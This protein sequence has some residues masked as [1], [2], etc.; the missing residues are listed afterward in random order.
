[1]FTDIERNEII[2]LIKHEVTP[3]IG[4]TEP[5]A[6][7]LAVAKA[8]EVLGVLPDK[9]EVFLSTNMLKN[10]MGVG[11]PGTGMVGL[12]I[13]IALGALIG[14]SEYKLQVLKDVTPATLELGKKMINEK[15]IN[16]FLKHK[17]SEKLYIEINAKSAN[18]KV[19]V[20][21]SRDHTRFSH[22]EKNGEI[23][24]HLNDETDG[25]ASQEKTVNLSFN[26][27]CDLALE[28]PIEELRFILQTAV[29][30]KAASNESMKGQYGH[31]VAQT[32]SHGSQQ[33]IMGNTIFTRMLSVTA[34]ACDA[35]MAGAMFPVMSNSGSGNQGIAA[36]LP[37][38]VFAEETGKSEDELIRALA[39]SHLMTIYIKQSL[40]RLSGLCGAIVAATGSACG[41]T[42]LM[43]GTREQI[44][45][46]I[47]NM[48]GNITGMI[49]DGAKPSCALK[50]SNGVSTAT[51]SALMA[52][53]NKVVTSIEGITDEDV[54][55]T[56]LNLTKIGSE[57][58]NETDRMVL[59]IMTTKGE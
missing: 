18:E 49:C 30:N 42:Y 9:I 25:T 20:I 58:M 4:C 1:M 11:I 38:S 40:G 16:V 24:L 54:D 47:K 44:A 36:T 35:R 23:L 2:A 57:G 41:I 52:I 17:I 26:K 37:V 56:I 6:V 3:A 50:V 48:I 10:A 27:V 55:K 29:M 8:K 32:V 46:S 33:N 5:V 28:S 51:L 31:S 21:I 34:A 53:D 45:Y 43:G 39:L 15:I 13:A 12:P 59:E 22:I 19:Q 14:K 7:A